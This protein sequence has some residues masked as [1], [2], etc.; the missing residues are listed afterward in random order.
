M[1]LIIGLLYLSYKLDV[2]NFN[3]LI[4][5]SNIIFRRIIATAFHQNRVIKINDTV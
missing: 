5:V 2:E 4:S 1:R 3:Q